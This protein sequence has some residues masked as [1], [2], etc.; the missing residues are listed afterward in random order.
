MARG[1]FQPR[2]IAVTRQVKQSAAAGTATT[3][4]RSPSWWPTTAT[5]AAT[6]AGVA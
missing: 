3:A 4:V 2:R 5:R 6:S 1:A